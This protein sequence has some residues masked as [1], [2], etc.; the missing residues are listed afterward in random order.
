MTNKK[1]KKSKG[2]GQK[3]IIQLSANSSAEPVYTSKSSSTKAS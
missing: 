3:K 2:R 1:E